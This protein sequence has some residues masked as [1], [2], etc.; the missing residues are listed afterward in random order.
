MQ[1]DPIFHTRKSTRLKGFDYSQAGGY[2][3]TV[4]TFRR[5]NLFGEVVDGE[6]Q[7]NALGRIVQEEWFR[8]AKIRKEIRLLEDEFVV[9]PNHIHGIVWI[10]I[11]SVG[12]D[13]VRPV[14]NAKGIPPGKNE[15]NLDPGSDMMVING[16]TRRVS[17]HRKPKTLGSFVAG[18]KSSVT[19]R[20]G[21][22][23]NSANIWHMPRRSQTA[24]GGI[25]AVRRR[26]SVNFN[27]IAGYILDNPLNW[28][29]DE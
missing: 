8:S 20:A 1:L 12:A 3:V 19:H 27:L 23:L 6:M 26:C 17:Q 22:E 7:V 25:D 4:V 13:G 28:D 15:G 14:T 16:D 5:E 10:E 9:M 11:D 2:F 29:K 18:F 21:I 24:I